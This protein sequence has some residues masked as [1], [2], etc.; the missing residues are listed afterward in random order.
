MKLL[1]KLTRLPT[2][3][4]TLS[5]LA[6]ISVVLGCGVIPAGQASTRTLNVTGFTTLLV[7]M[8]Y[9]ENTAVSAQVPGIARSKGGA[10]AFV[11]RLVMQTILDVLELQARSALLPDAVI[12]A[13]LDQLSVTISYEPLLGPKFTPD[14]TQDAE[15]D[16]INKCIIVGNSVTG[17]CAKMAMG[18]CDTPVVNMVAI[19]G[20]PGTHLSISGTLIKKNPVETTNIIMANW[21]RSMW[22]SVVNR[23]IRMLAWG[24]FGSHFFSA[25][26]TF[27]GN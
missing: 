20:V 9:T 10:Q 3:A 24:P 14:P 5:L 23:A 13:I 7:A 25:V 8:A 12:S 6:T 16:T 22:Q 1:T 17:L 19:T 21:Q 4:I 2:D 11:Q 15:N 18:K 26:A 27:G